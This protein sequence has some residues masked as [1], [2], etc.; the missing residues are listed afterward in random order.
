MPKRAV[1][2]LLPNPWPACSTSSRSPA[3]A[4]DHA[5]ILAGSGTDKEL[6]RAVL[7][8]FGAHRDQHL[9]Q[10]IAPLDGL[11][12]HL[13]IVD[14]PNVMQIED[15]E[16]L[17]QHACLNAIE[18]FLAGFARAVLEGRGNPGPIQNLLHVLRVT[19]VVRVDRLEPVEV[20]GVR[21]EPFA[22]GLEGGARSIV[23]WITLVT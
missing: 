11:R 8:S 2:S 10:Q 13:G 20:A 5:V 21:I 4:A 15:V 17:L 16:G 19:L 12:C 1:K 14:G 18:A 9:R 3:R 23:V 7:G 22:L 6:S